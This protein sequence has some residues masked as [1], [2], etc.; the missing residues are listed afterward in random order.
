MR[1]GKGRTQIDDVF[2]EPSA[3]AGAIRVHVVEHASPPD[4][5]LEEARRGYDLLLLGMRSEWGLETNLVSLRKQRVLAE[6]PVS[7]LAIHSPSDPMAAV[8]A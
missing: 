6:V 5:V 8:Q 7:I 3:D 1:P 2:S 4:A